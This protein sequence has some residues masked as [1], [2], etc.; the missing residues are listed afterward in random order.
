MV[1]KRAKI[2]NSFTSFVE[3]KHQILKTTTQLLKI[4]E[5]KLN[6][7]DIQ[8][9]QKFKQELSTDL[10]FKILCI[11]DFSSGKS[12][13]INQFLLQKDILPAFPK[14]TTTRP[15]IIRFGETLKAHLYFQDGSQEEVCE[16]VA[17]RLLETVSVGGSDVEQVSY[18]V[19][20]SPSAILQD[21]IELVDAPGLNDPDAERMKQTF[22]YLHNADAILFFLNAQQ[23]WTRYQTKF[24]EQ[25]LLSKR[26]IDKLFIIA[27]YWDQIDSSEREDV[28]DYLQQQLRVSLGKTLPDAERRSIVN[29]Q[30]LPVSSKTGENSDQVKQVVW[31]YLGERKFYDVLANR[32][33]RL[34]SYIGNYTKSLDEQI[35]LVKQDRK[36]REKRRIALES[37][38]SD[39]ARQREQ[40]NLNLKQALR[41]EFEEYKSILED[42]FDQLIRKMKMMVDQILQDNPSKD[43]INVLLSSQ[44]SRLQDNLMREMKSK[45]R[46]FLEQVKDRIEEQKGMIDLPPNSVSNIEDYFLKLDR[47]SKIESSQT[48]T[49]TSGVVGIAGLL[50]GAGT[51]MQSAAAPVVTQGA[52]SALGGWI[53]GST[54]TVASASSFM[55]FGLPGVVIGATALCGALYFKRKSSQEIISQLKKTAIQIEQSMID[56]KWKIVDQIANNQ[57]QNIGNICQDVDYEI[58][59]TYQQK[60]EE[61]MQ[62]DSIVDQGAQLEAL[63]KMIGKMRVEVN[64]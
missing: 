40:F 54:T 41:P 8:L 12:T 39:Y 38:I 30:V 5:A 3:R 10:S 47:V 43:N 45:E 19:V 18:V 60:L 53:F 59:Q 24:F 26:D 4:V 44:L 23:P 46:K 55:A 62:I 17:Q 58:N 33:Q 13:F 9:L 22:D 35:L 64:P 7:Q 29:L 32:I 51:L 61:L 50:I 63:S 25:E 21:G 57:N 48:A 49:V 6:S 20:E 11:G 42:L 37:E 16:Q 14:P 2:M 52:I 36:S 15:T 1:N 31:D 56:Q 34:N 28:L 27:N